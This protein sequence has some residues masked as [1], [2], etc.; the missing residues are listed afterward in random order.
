MARAR[1]HPSRSRSTRLRMVGAVAL[2]LAAAVV[3][4]QPAANA[5]GLT[6][7]PKGKI[8][9]PTNA[10]VA[11]SCKFTVDK[12]SPAN[13]YA[14]TITLTANAWPTTLDGY[15]DNRFTQVDCYVLPAGETDPANALAQIH[16]F[17][18]SGTVVPTSKSFTI[19]FAE[20]YTV[21]GHAFT[22]LKNGDT[23]S[24]AHVCA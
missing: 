19:G 12:V 16:P 5:A 14:T 23:S 22:K 3:V 20:S 8:V 13:G 21:C 7:T 6:L 4:G 17:A 9:E 10:D 2:A 15:R 18:N 11:A 24:T 1:V